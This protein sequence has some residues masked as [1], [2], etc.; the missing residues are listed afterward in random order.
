MEEELVIKSKRGDKE[1]FSQLVDGYYNQM[2]LLSL[3][4][5]KNPYD[6]GDACQE[7]FLTAYRKIRSLRANNRFKSWLSKIIWNCS[8]DLYVKNNRSPLSEEFIDLGEFYKEDTLKNADVYHY[9]LQLKDE[10]RDVLILRYF[11]DLKLKEIARLTGRPVG[12]VKSRLR[13]ALM[14]MKGLMENEYEG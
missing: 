10:Y 11:H 1:A 5:L 13:Y 14:A 6:A 3:S 2:F 8:K 4:I 12:T 9:L 7:G